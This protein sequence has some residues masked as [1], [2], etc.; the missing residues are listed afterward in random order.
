VATLDT[1]K[2][3]VAETAGV[4][5]A[6]LSS[7]IER[8]TLRLTADQWGAA[9][10]DAVCYM[11]GHL[12]CMSRHGASQGRAAAAGGGIASETVPAG[13]SRSYSAPTTRTTEEAMLAATAPGRDFLALRAQ[14]VIGPQLVAP[15]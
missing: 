13:H 7:F 8:A 5:D 3:L 6:T 12:L 14:A 2:L 9:Y 10:E 4:A 1:F 15:A 11:A